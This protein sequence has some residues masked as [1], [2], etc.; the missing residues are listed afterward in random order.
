MAKA[1]FEMITK[2]TP[3]LTVELRAWNAKIS[4]SNRVVKNDKPT[5]ISGFFT[6]PDSF[7][8]STYKF[9][10]T[11]AY[12]TLNPAAKEFTSKYLNKLSYARK[13]ICTSEKDVTVY[14]WMII[15]IDPESERSRRGTNSTDDELRYCIDLAYHIA[16]DIDEL[17]GASYVGTSGNGA[18][19]LSRID[20]KV[21]KQ[22]IN[23]IKSFINHI[24]KTYSTEKAVID[25]DSWHPLKMLS[26]P[27][28]IKYKGEFH[29]PDRPWRMAR[30][31]DFPP[32]A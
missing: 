8:V 17:K 14:K 3:G 4:P 21:D 26:V 2:Q 6:D 16:D 20:E 13:G 23:M 5:I 29:T 22:S 1:F 10:N 32:K 28:T 7:Y 27:G 31:F 25:R 11:S 24:S 19:V 15:D 18:F 12:M 9:Q 30:I